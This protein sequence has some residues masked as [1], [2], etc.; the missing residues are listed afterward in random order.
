MF[1]GL[2]LALLL[3]FA[4]ESQASGTILKGDFFGK[5]MAYAKVPGDE[6]FLQ[7]ANS[8]DLLIGLHDCLNYNSELKILLMNRAQELE[9]KGFRPNRVLFESMDPQSSHLSTLKI[10]FEYSNSRGILVVDYFA[11]SLNWN[12]DNTN[13]RQ[14]SDLV[15]GDINID[16]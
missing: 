4:G 1:K 7:S 13:I 14:V 8:D 16:W 10:T 6:G 15:M 5:E 11:G 12:P 9:E 3:A 2:V